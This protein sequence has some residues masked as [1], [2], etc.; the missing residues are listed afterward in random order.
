[1]RSGESQAV[2]I[3][4]PKS[5]RAHLRVKSELETTVRPSTKVVAHA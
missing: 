4:T 3:R 1:L 2:N 5:G